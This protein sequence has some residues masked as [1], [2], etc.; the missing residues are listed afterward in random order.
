[1][2]STHVS[3][4]TIEDNILPSVQTADTN[5]KTLIAGLGD[6]PTPQD[7]LLMQATLTIFTVMIEI[8]TT[9]TKVLGDAMKGIVQKSG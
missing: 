8:H 2:A 6:N 3:F 1:M 5:L 4:Q 7:L 9:M